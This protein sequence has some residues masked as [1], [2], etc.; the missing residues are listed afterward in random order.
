MVLGGVAKLGKTRPI[1]KIFFFA[2][3]CYPPQN[4]YIN[5]PPLIKNIQ[6]SRE[7]SPKG[8]PGEGFAKGG[9]GQGSSRGKGK[10]KNSVRDPVRDP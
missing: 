7:G 1:F 2:K 9:V 3:F 8:G 5:P 10:A 6:G 4:P